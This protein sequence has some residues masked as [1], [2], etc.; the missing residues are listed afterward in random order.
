MCLHLLGTMKR[1]RSNIS[2]RKMTDMFGYD[3]TLAS[4][5]SDSDHDERQKQRMPAAYVWNR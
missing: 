5:S 4:T 2:T 1:Y 3:A